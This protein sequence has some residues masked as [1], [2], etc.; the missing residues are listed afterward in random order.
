M[1]DNEGAALA[2]T[3][4]G[5]LPREVSVLLVQFAIVLGKTTTYPPNHPEL[6]RAVETAHARIDRYLRAHGP[7]TVGVARQRLVVNGFPADFTNSVVR[8][9]AQ[10]LHRRRVGGMVINPG[11]TAEE[12]TDALRAIA[13]DAAG[14]VGLVEAKWPNLVFTAPAYE[15]LRLAEG[16]VTPGGAGDQIWISLAQAALTPDAGQAEAADLAD[17]DHY[18]PFDSFARADEPSSAPDPAD[19]D[20]DVTEVAAA[21]DATPSPQADAAVLDKLAEM[22]KGA[23]NDPRA[24]TISRRAGDLV[25]ALRPETLRRILATADETSRTSFLVSAS[26]GMPVGA[27]LEL[28][29]ASADVSK[30]TVSH[31]LLRIC[32]KLAQHADGQSNASIEADAT[33]RE[34]LRELVRGWTLDDPNPGQYTALLD[35]LGGAAPVE[36]RSRSDDIEPQRI[37]AMALEGNFAG[38]AVD[39]AIDTAARTDPNA[40]VAALQRAGDRPSVAPIVRRLAERHL[41]AL[42]ERADA[43]AAVEWIVGRAGVGAVDTLLDTLETS[44]SRALRRRVVTLLTGIGP[45]IGPACVQRLEGRPWYMQRN[46]LALLAS[47]PAPPPGFSARPWAL[48]EDGRVRREALRLLLRSRATRDEAIGMSLR[49]DDPAVLRQGLFAAV[50]SCP[51][52]TIP[53]LLVM[54]DSAGESEIR[55]LAIRALGSART[56]ALLDWLVLRATVRRGIL[57]RE[58]LAP[59]SPEL[60]AA[61]GALAHSW[62][63]DP[64][65]ARVLHLARTSGDPD[66]A[67]AAGPES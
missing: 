30:Q 5:P 31:G 24:A 12:L 17:L 23:G 42:L 18:V 54:A 51:P 33:L 64:A 39:R 61:L 19:D 25:R 7:I 40:L 50:E 13:E 48:H 56:P 14:A 29:R 32:S 41:T 37:V 2:P 35:R 43:V 6:R 46:L 26:A 52:A 45:A 62:R 9:L 66:I 57:R 59:K 1:I 27:V 28:V 67:G 3:S 38:V 16:D 20:P 58:H 53:R 63:A 4:P 15:Q 55:T 10:R 34:M 36:R 11:I 21:I 47:L 60:L 44:Q 65:A 22:A 49:D 8:E